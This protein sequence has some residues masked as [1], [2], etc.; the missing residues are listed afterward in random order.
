[1]GFARRFKQGVQKILLLALLI[2]ISGWGAEPTLSQPFD[3]SKEFPNLFLPTEFRNRASS[4][5][6]HE[7]LKKQHALLD[8]ALGSVFERLVVPIVPEGESSVKQ[9]RYF[10][11]LRGRL[12]QVD[13]GMKLYASGGVVRTA[14]S[15]LYDEVYQELE[16]DPQKDPSQVLEEIAHSKQDLPAIRVRGIGSDFDML[17]QSSNGKT[18]ELQTL[19]TQI[20]NSASHTLDAKLD[21]YALKNTFFTLGDVRDYDSQIERSTRQGGSTVDYLAFDLTSQKLRDPPRFPGLTDKIVSGRYEFAPPIAGATP[22]DLGDSVIR[23]ARTFLE[24]P[25]IELEN[26]DYYREQIHA[27]NIQL[28]HGKNLSERARGQFAKGIRNSRYFGAHNRFYRAKP[29]TAEA[30]VLKLAKKLGDGNSSSLLPEF[31]DSRKIALRSQD[32]SELNGLPKELLTSVSEFKTKYTDK[33][34]LHHGTPSVENGLAILRQGLFLSKS[35]QGTAVYGRGVYSSPDLNVSKS[36]AGDS[37][38]IFDLVVKDDP[39]VN[40]LDWEKVEHHPFIRKSIN[41]AKKQGRDIFEYISR[42]HGIDIIKNNHVLIQNSDAIALPDGL[43]SIVQS[44]ANK[45]IDTKTFNPGDIQQFCQLSEYL[46]RTG[47]K[48]PLTPEQWQGLYE[49]IIRPIRPIKGMKNLTYVRAASLAS[50]IRSGKFV[51]VDK[52]LEPLSRDLLLHYNTTLGAELISFIKNP[53]MQ[54][55]LL[56]IAFASY[57]SEVQKAA[58]QAVDWSKYPM[59]EYDRALAN[60]LLDQR[61]LVLNAKLQAVLKRPASSQADIFELATKNLLSSVAKCKFDSLC[62]IHKHLNFIR[63]VILA[64]KYMPPEQDLESLTRTLILNNYTHWPSRLGVELIPLIK[65]QVTQTDLLETA[66]SSRHPE[67]Q[68]SALHALESSKEMMPQFDRL[69]EKTLF[70]GN[71]ESFPIKLKAV[72]KRPPLIQNAIFDKALEASATD[73]VDFWNSQNVQNFLY[74]ARETGFYQPDRRLVE[75]WARKQL[76]S[77]DDRNTWAAW[78]VLQ[79]ALRQ[80]DNWPKDLVRSYISDYRVPREKRKQVAKLLN[81]KADH[82]VTLLLK[83]LF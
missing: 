19:A 36:Y 70:E 77:K 13:P 6:P 65:D 46:E 25:W 62:G 20:T 31:A 74:K 83:R 40:I 68:S 23:G 26:E 82:C 18:G 3:A 11:Y 54:E 72:L 59:P 4:E 33:G 48:S 5:I 75:A 63:E 73:N 14:I 29:E 52:D 49:S 61:E 17:V 47:E 8:Q 51:P 53:A 41:E 50:G 39:R 58:L 15:Y 45:L 12:L 78:G 76:W 79:E 30:E 42:E 71:S 27:L 55:E 24:L 16:R 67:T 44:L 69:L 34:I 56:K 43:K 66:L 9:V 10:P 35:G 1:M 32:H 22:E 60:A 2:S 81:I 80:G 38:M 37:G 7:V 64:K 21:N 57:E 28:Q